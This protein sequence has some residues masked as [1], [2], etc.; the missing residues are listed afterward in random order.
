MN[1]SILK[2]QNKVEQFLNNHRCGSTDTY[3]YVSMGDNFVGKFKLSD[4]DIENFNKLYAKAISKGC[5]FNIAEKPNEYAIIIIDIDL[6]KL[7]DNHNERLYNDNMIIEIID[8]YREV[9][10]KYLKL[11]NDQ[12]SCSLFEKPQ[13]T[14]KQDK[15]KDGVHIIFQSVVCNTKLRYVIRNEV[16]KLLTNSKNFDGYSLDKVIDKQ[17]VKTNCWLLPGSKKK[18]GYLY[19][20]SKIY[21]INNDL[22]SIDKIKNDKNKML[23]Y[24]SLQTNTNCQ[25]YEAE[26]IDG[27]TMKTIETDFSNLCSKVVKVES[28]VNNNKETNN[29][30]N[31]DV[32][33]CLKCLPIDD[34]NDF[35]QWRDIAF[36]IHHELGYNGL[37][38]LKNWSSDG[39]G[40]DQTKVEQFYKN[41]KPKDNGLKIG[42]L[43]KLAKE[44]NSD[45]YKQLFKKNKEKNVDENSTEYD[46]NKNKFELNNFK[47]LDPIGF[48]TIRQDKTLIL[49]NKKDFTT[50]YENLLF[51]N[52]KNNIS[53]VSEWLKDPNNRTY[54]KIDFLPMQQAPLNIYNTFKGYE[55]EKI[56]IIKT[57]IDDSLMLKHI[58][59]LCNND[60]IVFNYFIKFLANLIKA[61]Y[62]ISKTAIILKSI[63]GCGK[64]TLF[65]WFGNNILGS[66]YYI[67]TDK[68]E[69][70]FGRFNSCIENKILIVMNE[71]N[72]KDTF[73]INENI[74][75]AITAKENNIEHKGKASYKNTNNIAYVFL[76]NNENPLK[77][78]H[79]DRR[80][81]G[82]EC[83]NNI[84]N[85][86]EYFKN[87]NDEINNKSY[88]RAFY[89]YLLTIDVDN[90]DFT[91]NRPTTNFYNNMKEL[92]TPII[93]KFFE[94][95]I[96]KY[97]SSTLIN[98]TASSLYDNFN[99]FIKDNNFKIEYTSTKF[100]IDIKNYEGIE[101]KRT[102]T[103]NQIIINIDLLKQYLTLKF[104]IEFSN[105]DFIDDNTNEKDSLDI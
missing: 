4:D 9:M 105:D 8:A 27:I 59:H 94:N 43:K 95:M 71:T 40:Y 19:E 33:K 35:E 41:I 78:P 72:G 46:L 93:A 29:D 90:Y 11:D 7:T 61:P 67:N 56:E 18:D 88:D 21:D 100:G 63:Q 99:I 65:D 82:I 64:D 70:I 104:K 87:L 85:N 32:T 26:F 89:N 53:F 14:I 60:E 86:F 101:K 84:A 68:S 69:L 97:N 102:K 62:N 6:E 37:D 24:Y 3:N 17:V 2:Y 42:T 96:D 20:L 48:A 16:L 47:L 98:I 51:N 83:D 1:N 73:S 79:D 12:L 22:V 28:I 50:V 49:R 57:N 13:P 31:T 76:T 74:K 81:C 66:D 80:F 5:I 38:I 55:A 39:N 77:V 25:E 30:I 45:L 92:N 36:I 58:K 15:I 34:Y 52:G 44:N 103:G 91:N 23:E 54:D 75:C 10:N